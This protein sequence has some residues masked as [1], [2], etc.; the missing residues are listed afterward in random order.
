M[1][2]SDSEH[3]LHEVCPLKNVQPLGNAA[4][5]GMSTAEL[6]DWWIGKDGSEI[7]MPKRRKEG[8]WIPSG[9]QVEEMI[10]NFMHNKNYVGNQVA[11]YFG[12]TLPRDVMQ[13]WNNDIKLYTGT[14]PDNHPLSL[15]PRNISS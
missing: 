9:K 8:N 4:E 3:R 6:P 14:D 7:V 15:A 5:I 11:K 13:K 12:T 1:S 10:Y 2:D